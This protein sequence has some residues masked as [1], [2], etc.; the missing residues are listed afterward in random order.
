LLIAASLEE[1]QRVVEVTMYPDTTPSY[2][3]S[4]RQLAAQV[5]V[6]WGLVP[7]YL[8]NM[9][10]ILKKSPPSRTN[11]LM[12]YNFETLDQYVFHFLPHAHAPPHTHH[13]HCTPLIPD[14]FMFEMQRA[15]PVCG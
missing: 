5:D 15:R 10:R 13:A 7:T 1:H 3:V 14:I 9:K 4:T 12:L 2:R 8:E 11:I 6:H